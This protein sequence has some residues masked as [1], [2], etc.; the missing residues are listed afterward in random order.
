MSNEIQIQRPYRHFKGKLYYVHSIVKHSETGE[1][2]VSY[3][4]L[5]PPYYMYVRP[6]SMFKEKVE[7]GREDNITNQNYRFELYTGK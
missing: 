1:E 4:M 7:E 5:Y 3:Q 2:L 6:L